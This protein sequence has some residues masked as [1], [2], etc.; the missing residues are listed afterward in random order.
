MTIEAKSFYENVMFS[1]ALSACTGVEIE[2]RTTWVPSG[3]AIR[4]YPQC[5]AAALYMERLSKAEASNGPTGRLDYKVTFCRENALMPTI[6]K[7]TTVGGLKM[8]EAR[9]L[10]RK[11]S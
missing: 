10:L 8:D 2:E 9:D 6:R 11:E 5:Q 7:C 1:H 3:R 4:D